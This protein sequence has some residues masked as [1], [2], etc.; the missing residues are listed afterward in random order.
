MLP[1]LSSV[2][3]PMNIL[4]IKLGAT[5][6]VVRTTP[7]LRRLNDPITWLTAA[8]NVPLLDELKQNLKCLAWEQR[9]LVSNAKYDLIINLEDTPDV[10]FYL[11]TL[12][13]ER[14]F[15]AH[16]SEGVMHYTEDSSGWFDLSLISKFGRQ[17]A[18][19]V[20][21]L[22]RQTYQ[23]LIFGGLGFRFSEEKYV[24]PEPVETGLKADVAIAPEA[25]LVWPMK[26]W[27]Y[28]GELQRKL[29]TEGLRVNVLPIRPSLRQH[30]ADVR[31]HRCLVSADS[32]PMHLALGIGTPCVTLFSCTSPWEIHDYGL[33][34]KIV[35]PLLESFFYKRDYDRR[36]TTAISVEEVFDAV[37]A[38]L[39]A[40]VRGSPIKA[41]CEK[42]SVKPRHN[43]QGDG[44]CP[45]LHVDLN[46]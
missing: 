12:R 46:S 43:A 26:Q 25:G 23:E 14:L 5:G 21:F 34:K 27:A 22:N 30:L 11:N 19:R 42:L 13:Y 33:Q 6:D 45:D 40:P 32:L 3:H 24:L 9:H 1:S 16:S 10:A 8:K 4:I 29:E 35:S 39:T 36:A 18:D 41:I 28:Y 44:P 2:S 7:L 38:Q 37:M 31:N 15:G 20:K 17:E